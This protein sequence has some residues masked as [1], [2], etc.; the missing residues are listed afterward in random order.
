VRAITTQANGTT[1]MQQQQYT[2]VN[3]PWPQHCSH[4]KGAFKSKKKYFLKVSWF[5]FESE[6]NNDV[7]INT[8]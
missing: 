1:L 2:M 6:N 8:N 4:S 5:L 7:K 3:Y